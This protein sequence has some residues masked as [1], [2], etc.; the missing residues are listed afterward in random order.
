[1][2]K[3]DLIHLAGDHAQAHLLITRG[4]IPEARA[5]VSQLARDGISQ[6]DTQPI[7]DAI[8]D[9]EFVANQADERKRDMRYYLGLRTTWSR[10]IWLIAATLGGV[11][12]LLKGSSAVARGMARG[13][14]TGITT[15]EYTKHGSYLWTRPI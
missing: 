7:L 2:A 1:M 12:A 15:Q 3:G 8:R 11:H 5:L 4:K 14:T 10:S 13:L 6:A 9:R